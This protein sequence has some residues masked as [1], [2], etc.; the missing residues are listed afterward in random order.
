[1]LLTAM[2]SLEISQAYNQ[3]FLEGAS[4]PGIVTEM[5]RRTLN[6]DKHSRQ[7]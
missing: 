6:C 4:K 2:C 7:A 5:Q 1:M 3:T